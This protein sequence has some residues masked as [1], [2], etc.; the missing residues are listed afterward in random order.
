[1]GERRQ[2]AGDCRRC[3]PVTSGRSGISQVKCA[4]IDSCQLKPAQVDANTPHRIASPRSAA[5]SRPMHIYTSR[6]AASNRNDSYAPG[7]R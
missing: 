4:E 2:H 6:P 1:V 3:S 5:P 7:A